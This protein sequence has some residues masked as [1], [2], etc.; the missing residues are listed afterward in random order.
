MTEVPF[1]SP[2]MSYLLPGMPTW[3]IVLKQPSWNLQQTWGYA[4][5]NR[6]ETKR[7]HVSNNSVKL[8]CQAWIA[9]SYTSFMKIN[10]YCYFCLSLWAVKPI[11]KGFRVQSK[12]MSRVQMLEKYTQD[13]RTQLMMSE[14]SQGVAR[15]LYHGDKIPKSGQVRDL[16]HCPWN[17]LES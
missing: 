8:P 15:V 4:E 12:K 16:S 14:Q 6:A 1:T 10:P 2:S 9:Y 11:H 7:S 3:W 5:D 13:T 17:S